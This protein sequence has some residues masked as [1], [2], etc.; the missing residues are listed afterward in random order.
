MSC[1]LPITKC[2]SQYIDGSY[3]PMRHYSTS[4]LY[5][6]YFYI[7]IHSCF[8]SPSST[9]QYNHYDASYCHLYTKIQR[10]N[11]ISYGQLLQHNTTIHHIANFYSTMHWC[12]LSTHLQH[13][14]S[15]LHI[16]HNTWTA[17][18]H[19]AYLYNTITIQ[20]CHFYTTINRSYRLVLKKGIWECV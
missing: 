2:T 19:N 4:T 9:S 1:I 3:R 6:T 20:H 11:D 13:N 10:Y 7:T 18:L 12:F 16:D 5:I 14:N 15:M 8:I 17:M